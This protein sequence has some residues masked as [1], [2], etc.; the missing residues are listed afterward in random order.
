MKKFVC[1]VVC[2]ILLLAISDFLSGKMFAYMISHAKGGE[3][4][5]NNFICDRV[6]SDI[7]VFG[8]SRA[9]HH[10]NP[11]II[12]DSLNMSCYNCGQDGNGAILNYGRYQLILQRYQPK[13]LIYDL[14]S[15]FDFLEGEDNHKYLGWLKA[16]YDRPGIADIF[17]SIDETEK[18]KMQSFFYRYNT[19]FIQ[20]VSDF[21][22]PLQS[23]GI[24]GFRPE[25]RE[26]DTMKISAIPTDKHKLDN[27]KINYLKKI[28]IE[29]NSTKVI[30]VISPRWNGWNGMNAEEQQFVE[31]FCQQYN[32]PFIDLSN[33]FLHENKFFQDGSHLNSRGADEYTRKLIRFIRPYIM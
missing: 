5:R 22:H 18:Y 10:Y 9:L 20:I 1:K 7:L 11:L 4:W 21:I 28:V 15:G 26:M 8:S 12:M 29:S 31:S 17:K 3:N 33:L 16:Y 27:L 19:K 14:T 6:D 32:I 13:L 30:F 25:E 2:F 23:D 24:F